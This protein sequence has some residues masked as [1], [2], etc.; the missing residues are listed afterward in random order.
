MR[1]KKTKK[2]HIHRRE[3]VLTSTTSSQPVPK[4]VEQM[5]KSTNRAYLGTAFLV[6]VSICS[7]QQ[8]SC[9]GQTMKRTFNLDTIWF[10]PGNNTSSLS[11]VRVVYSE[12]L[13]KGC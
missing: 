4:T 6:D 2:K 13:V 3:M 8:L 9:G 12:A 1:R 10:E 11:R 5:Q 7:M